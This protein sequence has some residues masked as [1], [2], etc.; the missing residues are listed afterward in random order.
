MMLD[1]YNRK[2]TREQAKKLMIGKIL[3]DIRDNFWG[4]REAWASTWKEFLA[5]WNEI[6][7]LINI[8]DHT[9]LDELRHDCVHIYQYIM[10]FDDDPNSVSAVWACPDEQD[11]GLCINTIVDHLVQINNR[12]ISES[13]N[14][15]ATA[16]I[17]NSDMCSKANLTDVD[18]ETVEALVRS[19]CVR[20]LRYGANNK[21]EFDMEALEKEMRD[22]YVLGKGEVRAMLPFF[23]FSGAVKIESLFDSAGLPKEKL[24]REM[25]RTICSFQSGLERQ[26][27]LEIVEE[28]ILLLARLGVDNS[29]E[30]PIFEFMKSVLKMQRR[31]WQLFYHKDYRT[32][33]RLK[34]LFSIWQ[35][36][37][38]QIAYDDPK[39]LAAPELT[40]AC[41]LEPLTPD[42]QEGLVIYMKSISLG[43]IE[44][45]IFAWFDVLKS[46]CTDARADTSPLWAVWL[47]AS[48]LKNKKML[49]AMPEVTLANAGT[50]YAFLAKEFFKMRGINRES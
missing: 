19:H 1:R 39:R 3:D 6:Y 10:E 24:D 37:Q 47:Q 31:D 11:E 50:A 8:D 29:G 13:G 42:M 27:A 21:L 7:R 20:P 33:I 14:A 44:D 5:C 35:Y 26:H 28:T 41:Y 43:E 48:S 34:H 2:I 17:M 38:K 15:D 46:A 18:K 23:E 45:L 36:L 40:D 49:D 12:F 22:R 9:R 30:Q 25:L 16:P 32:E 4:D